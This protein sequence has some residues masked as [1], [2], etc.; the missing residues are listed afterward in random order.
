MSLCPV[1]NGDDNINK[2]QYLVNGDNYKL[3]IEEQGKSTKMTYNLKITGGYTDGSS[4]PTDLT[5]T[6]FTPE[7]LEVQAGNTGTVVMELRTAEN[8]R[9]N[10][11]YPTEKLKVEFAQDQSTCS[12]TIATA[13]YPG[14][15]NIKITCTKT[16]TTNSFS[17]SVEGTKIAK[18]V[19]LTIVNAPAY[20]LEVENSST[21]SVSGDKY[22]RSLESQGRL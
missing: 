9:K 21:F 17:V 1:T 5:K 11:W 3:I 13:D 7:K 10:Y 22:T 6:V 12:Y 14:R 2:F 18:T 15:Y 19:G 20:Y 4:A 8:K 16:T